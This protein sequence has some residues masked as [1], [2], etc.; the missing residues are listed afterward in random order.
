MEKAP[1]CRHAPQPSSELDTFL[2][3]EALP[4][5]CGALAQESVPVVVELPGPGGWRVVGVRHPSHALE[6]LEVPPAAAWIVQR[7]GCSGLVTRLVLLDQ[8]GEVI[9][10]IVP[11]GG[12]GEPE[13]IAWRVQLLV[14]IVGS[15]AA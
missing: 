13:P 15:Q 6:L 4:G 3:L 8:H 12:L 11:A 5:L 7:P 14:S 2:P 10:S 1:C 9:A